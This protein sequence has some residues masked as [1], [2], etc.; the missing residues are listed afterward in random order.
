MTVLYDRV[1]ATRAPGHGGAHFNRQRAPPC[2]LG[3]AGRRKSRSRL[4]ANLLLRACVAPVADLGATNLDRPDAG[5]DRAMRPWRDARRRS[6]PSGNFMSFTATK[7]SASAISAWPAFCG[8]HA[9]VRLESTDDGESQI[10]TLPSVRS[11][12]GSDNP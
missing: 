1:S 7:A 9:Q 3:K 6:R 5:L 8:L 11:R 12:H 10:A 2:T 4:E